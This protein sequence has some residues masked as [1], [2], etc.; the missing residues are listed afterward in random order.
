[1]Q[2]TFVFMTR[3]KYLKRNMTAMW[4]EY[5]TQVKNISWDF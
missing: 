4:T 1:M 2:R 3:Q 5:M